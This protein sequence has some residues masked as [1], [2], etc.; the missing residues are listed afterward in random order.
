MVINGRAA[1]RDAVPL[2]EVTDVAGPSGSHPYSEA[3][4]RGKAALACSKASQKAI[5]QK[6]TKKPITE[7]TKARE[8]EVEDVGQARPIVYNFR[9]AK[10]AVQTIKPYPVCDETLRRHLL[11]G[12]PHPF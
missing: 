10:F 5:K 3:A 8:I 4:K 7:K 11:V 9:F 6:P 2:P 12:K 1:N